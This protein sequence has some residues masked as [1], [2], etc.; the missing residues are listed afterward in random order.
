MKYSRKTFFAFFLIIL[1]IFPVKKASAQY[2]GMGAFR[3][4]QSRQ[5][6]NQQMN[7]MMQ[8]NALRNSGAF[9]N[10]K[11]TFLVTMKDGTEKEVKSSIY[12]DTIINK[13]YLLLEDKSFK[14]ADTNR[15]KKIYPSQTVNIRRDI[16][17]SGASLL[18]RSNMKA[19]PAEYYTGVAKDS[20]WM[21]KVISGPISVY[22]FLSE[23]DGQNFD[24]SSIV[25]IQ[26]NDGPVISFTVDHLKEMIGQD[27][28]NALEIIQHDDYLRAIKRYNRDMK[29]VVKK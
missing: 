7:T 19:P 21:F 28:V 24:P 3:A 29:K 9:Y 12:S 23:E 26:L 18:S 25:G 11:Y 8:T 20:C 10:Q 14:K 1:F 17:V 13:N 15:F 6:A 2:P 4:Q 16:S 22:S 27:D 5:F